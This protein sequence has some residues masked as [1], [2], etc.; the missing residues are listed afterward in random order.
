MTD[1]L[2]EEEIYVTA[3]FAQEMVTNAWAEL[4]KRQSWIEESYALT[5]DSVWIRRKDDW[6]AFAAHTFCVLLSLAPFY[7]WWAKEF[8]QDYTDQGDLFELLTEESLVF[9]F[10]GWT[11]HRT[12]WARSNTA[13]L[14]QI[15]D[16]VASCLGEELVHPGLWNQSGAKEMGLDLLCY[17][18]FSDGRVGIPVYLMQCASSGNW[19]SKLHTP[20]L[21]V[22]N[23]MITFRNQIQRAF[24]TPFSFLDEEFARNC[25]HVKGLFLDRCRLLKDSRAWISQPLTHRI[26]EWAEPRI[27][28]L[29]EKSK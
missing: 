16:S 25:V 14:S 23:A 8:G 3:D 12:G 26:I 27:E 19:K 4:R 11:V 18:G 13:N 22:W 1:V 28:V 17:R 15:V 9:H 24:S 5:V 7:D 20:D 21:N 2:L 6:R 10:I 29:L